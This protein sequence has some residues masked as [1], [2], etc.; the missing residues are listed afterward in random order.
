MLLVFRHKTF[1]WLAQMGRTYCKMNI[2]SFASLSGC[3]K[4]KYSCFVLYCFFGLP[5]CTEWGKQGEKGKEQGLKVWS[6][7]LSVPIVLAARIHSTAG[8]RK[9][10]LNQISGFQVED[11]R[12]WACT[13]AEISRGT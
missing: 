11:K 9:S 1:S 7:S 3:T 10:K 6:K 13:M 5:C 12:F 8:G 2:F 4:V